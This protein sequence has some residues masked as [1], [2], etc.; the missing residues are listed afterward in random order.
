[1]HHPG[2]T[3]GD[4]LRQASLLL[5]ACLYYSVSPDSDPRAGLGLSGMSSYSLLQL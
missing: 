5:S 2:H 4:W 1:M 3:A